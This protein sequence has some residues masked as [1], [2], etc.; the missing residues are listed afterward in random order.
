ML[1]MIRGL[2]SR[3][4]MRQ[5]SSYC[6]ECGRRGPPERGAAGNSRSFVQWISQQRPSTHVPRHGN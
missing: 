4:Q 1:H 5:A 3:M 6:L 2:E